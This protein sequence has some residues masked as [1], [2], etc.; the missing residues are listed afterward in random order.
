MS[1]INYKKILCCNI[2]NEKKC[3]YGDKCL[4]AHNLNEQIIDDNKKKIINMIKYEEDLSYLNICQDNDFYREL[5]IFTN[6]CKKCIDKKCSGGYNCKNGVL[7]DELKICKKDLITGR[8]CN[9]TKNKY[10]INGIHLTEKNLIP[11]NL[12]LYMYPNMNFLMFKMEN[13]KYYDMIFNKKIHLDDKNVMNIKR[14]I[15]E[16]NVK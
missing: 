16:N 3:S 1:S 14:I 8:C 9:E 10:C 15:N 13:S 7:T 4:F 12:Q 2:L 6:E 11:Y 5:L